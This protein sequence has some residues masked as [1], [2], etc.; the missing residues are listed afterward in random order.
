MSP[1]RHGVHK[2]NVLCTRWLKHNVITP[3][4]SIAA[5][6]DFIQKWNTEKARNIFIVAK[7]KHVF[8]IA[9]S[10]LKTAFKA[11][12]PW[13]ISFKNLF[14]GIGRRMASV[15]FSRF[16]QM[17]VLGLCWQVGM[18]LHE[19][20]RLNYCSNK[21][22]SPARDGLMVCSSSPGKFD[23]T[24]WEVIKTTSSQFGWSEVAMYHFYLKFIQI[25]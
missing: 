22:T 8:W 20:S 17:S 15:S 9:L 13:N 10:C 7:R 2:M 25:F 5:R 4:R 11:T 18:K 14:D 16:L 24:S 12:V 23:F 1:K 6:M 19:K 3:K 21:Y